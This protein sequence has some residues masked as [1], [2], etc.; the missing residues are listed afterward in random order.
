MLSKVQHDVTGYGKSTLGVL[1][2]LGVLGPRWTHLRRILDAFM[3]IL[4]DLT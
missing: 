2:V 4:A 3:A 1:G